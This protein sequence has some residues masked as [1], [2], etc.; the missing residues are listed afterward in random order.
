[1]RISDWS[2]DVGSSDLENGDEVLIDE[3]IAKNLDDGEIE[4]I[5]DTDYG[6]EFSDIVDAIQ[7]AAS[8][9]DRD[10]IQSAYFDHYKGLLDEAM[11]Q[12]GGS[13]L[14]E[15]SIDGK[16]SEERRGGK[17]VVSTCRSRWSPSP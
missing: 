16:R 11:L 9:A 6:G 3:E 2:S 4:D 13:K 7:W 8:D 10:A 15:V 1:M 14:Q 17:E 5:L 12:A